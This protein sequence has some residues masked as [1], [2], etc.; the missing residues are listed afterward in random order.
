MDLNVMELLVLARNE[1]ECNGICTA[2]HD[3]TVPPGLFLYILV[4]FLSKNLDD[5][6]FSNFRF[7]FFTEWD[8]KF[9]PQ[10]IHTTRGSNVQS[11]KVSGIPA[12]L[13]TISCFC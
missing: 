7:D 8:A 4:K 11:Q 6:S 10:K 3:T 12:C 1:S 5:E 9:P 13:R 2:S